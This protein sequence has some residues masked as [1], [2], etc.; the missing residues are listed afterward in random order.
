MCKLHEVCKQPK[1]YN[2]NWPAEDRTQIERMNVV[3]W[4]KREQ[5]HTY[6]ENDTSLPIVIL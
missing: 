3:N 6:N 2:T 5:K 1:I 4:T